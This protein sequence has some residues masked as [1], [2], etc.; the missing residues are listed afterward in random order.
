MTT[1]VLTHEEVG[2]LGGLSKAKNNREKIA[3]GERLAAER[4]LLE[5]QI[6]NLRA[7]NDLLIDAILKRGITPQELID[8]LRQVDSSAPLVVGGV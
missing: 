7:R 4:P 3:I 2:R 6:Q 5:A 8:L 1:A